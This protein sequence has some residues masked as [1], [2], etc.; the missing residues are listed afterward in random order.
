M[1]NNPLKET[2]I[3]QGDI[4]RV[5]VGRGWAIAKVV[6]K[7]G[8]GFIKIIYKNAR[9]NRTQNNE[10]RVEDVMTSDEAKAFKSGGGNT[11]IMRPSMGDTSSEEENDK[12]RGNVL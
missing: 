9:F 12:P 10:V 11:R 1:N 7:Q 5:P 8:A 6:A 2:E 3:V 4:V